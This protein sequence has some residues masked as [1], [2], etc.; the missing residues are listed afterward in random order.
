MYK[1]MTKGNPLKLIVMFSIPLILG[2][3]FQQMYQMADTFIVSKT[4]GVEAFAAV[5]ATGSINGLILGLAIGLTAG[6]SVIT[7]QRF[8]QK[9][10]TKIRQNLAASVII[11]GTMSVILTI[12]AVIFTRQ[13]LEFMNTPAELIEHSNSYL[14]VLFS[15]IGA[16]V[17][18]NLISNVLR[19]IGNSRAPLFFL[20]IT[21]IL[22]I[23]LDLLFILVFDMGVAGAGL[24]TVISQF[25]ASIVGLIYIKRYVPILRIHKE[26]WAAGFKQIKEHA[27]IAFPMG[28]QSSIIAIGSI[29]IQMTLNS[30]GP[31]A[32]AATTAAQKID[33]IATLPLVSF[34]I[35]MATFAAQNYGAGKVERV[36]QGVRTTMKVVLTYSAVVGLL[37]V[38][39]GRNLTS[40]FVG[41]ESTEILE[42]SQLY[43]ITNASFY[44]LLAM[45]FIY[46]Y[47]LQGLGRSTAPTLAGIMELFSR[48]AA[49]LLLSNTLGF[50]GVTLSNALA[51]LAA[52][53]P[54]TFSYYSLKRQLS[55]EERP[56]LLPKL[57]EL[58]R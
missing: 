35:T 21:S 27:A 42:L 9:D 36:W 6:L 25:V 56:K 47:T 5:G 28:F 32:V 2:N 38:L 26:D 55:G 50:A 39:F 37:L 44:F 31:T 46:R 3:L 54:L 19:S 10:E 33:G 1:D 51:W 53:I 16:A 49:A 22:N 8:G 13:I 58:I 15:G 40:L 34:G 7:A 52:L 11:S 43:F 57:A 41:S 17:M 14:S 18:F 29:A 24:A 23:G 20:I 4:I 45:L 12:L 30:L 48:V